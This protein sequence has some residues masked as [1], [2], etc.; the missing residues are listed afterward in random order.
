MATQGNGGSSPGPAEDP[1][2]PIPLGAQ[3]ERARIEFMYDGTGAPSARRSDEILVPSGRDR[4]RAQET[5][6][7]VL[8]SLAP[9]A[10]IAERNREPSEAAGLLRYR[11]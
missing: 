8:V 1:T 3:L 9:K 10:R 7:R 4:Q 11:A 2:G 6:T 5:A